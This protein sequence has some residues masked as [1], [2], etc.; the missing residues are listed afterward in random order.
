M[1]SATRCA[2]QVTAPGTWSLTALPSAA[3]LPADSARLRLVSA[4]ICGGDLAL[5]RGRNA[6]ARY[7][8]ILGHECVGQVVEAGPRSGVA[9]GEYVVVYPTISCGSC[10]ACA[11]G[12][13]NQ[14][15][16]MRVM[17]LSDPRGCFADQLVVP[18]SQLIPL[19]REVA[20]AYGALVEP[21]A[22]ACHVLRRAGSLA[23]ARALVIGCGVIGS[24]IAVALHAAG[25]ASVYGVDRYPSRRNNAVALGLAGFS[26]ATGADLTAWVAGE[27]GPVDVVFDTVCADDT[28]GLAVDALRPGGRLVTVASAAPGQRLGLRYDGFFL[29]ELQAVAARNYTPDDFVAAVDLLRP[30]RPD[31]SS[32]VTMTRPLSEFGRAIEELTSA[33]ER[34][35]KILLEPSSDS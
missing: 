25:T 14:C 10:A 6:V 19:D 28:T 3:D 17:G 18:G 34:H 20:E 4:G 21:M 35:L 31:L 24:V 26:T 7:P 16:T 11:D 22:V 13:R 8:L 23:G 27:V 33:P 2:V 9:A 29:K 1:G 12:R 32:L 15:P 30:R 5:L